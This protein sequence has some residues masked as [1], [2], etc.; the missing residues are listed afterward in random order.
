MLKILSKKQ[1]SVS[2]KKAATI[3]HDTRVFQKFHIQQQTWENTRIA[4]QKMWWHHKQIKPVPWCAS[5]WFICTLCHI[6]FYRWAAIT[7]IVNTNT[8]TI[9]MS[10]R[11]CHRHTQTKV[12]FYSWI[13]MGGLLQTKPCI[14]RWPRSK[15]T[16]L[17]GT[18]YHQI[19]SD[20]I[21][22]KDFAPL[23]SFLAIWTF[24]TIIRTVTGYTIIIFTGQWRRKRLLRVSL[25]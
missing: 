24:L 5:F 14:R 3:W 8:I 20:T 2:A 1:R 7:I 17:R 11:W 16:T 9:I 23:T 21:I 18:W 4:E 22:V 13:Q 15:V 12:T 10:K 6:L 25:L 19:V